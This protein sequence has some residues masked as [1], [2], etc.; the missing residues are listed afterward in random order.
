MTI[1]N[2]AMEA[3]CEKADGIFIPCT[4]FPAVQLI[5]QI[6]ADSNKPVITANQATFWQILRRISINQSINGYG[7][8]LNT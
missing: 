4:N 5:G 7:R 3:D 6:E 1:Y 2:L 8:L